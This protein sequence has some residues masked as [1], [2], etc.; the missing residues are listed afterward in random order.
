VG[1]AVRRQRRRRRHGARGRR[2]RQRLRHRRD[3]QLPGRQQQ[4]RE[5]RR[6]PRQVHEQR[7]TGSLA[8]TNAG[9]QDA[10]VAKVDA[11]GSRGW[12]SQFGT[13]SDDAGK[14]VSVDSS[15][16]IVAVGFT[17]GKLGSA[18]LGGTDAFVAQL[19]P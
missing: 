18:A 16:N 19:A 9:K 13:S 15:G 11:S 14:A 1:Q 10:F 4:R 17:D 3:L 8:G 6:V 5:L 7:Q 12:T 2:Q